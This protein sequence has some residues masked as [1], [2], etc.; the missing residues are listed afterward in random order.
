MGVKSKNIWSDSLLME[1][2][3]FFVLNATAHRW[4]LSS[5]YYSA[6]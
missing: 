5:A 1:L 2:K 4:M 6:G 3:K